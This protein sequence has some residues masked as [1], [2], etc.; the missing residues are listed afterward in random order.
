MYAN[1]IAAIA[2]QDERARYVD[3]LR[4]AY[5][6]DIDIVRLASELVVDSI[7]LPNEL[8]AA[9]IARLRAAR[10]KNRDFSRRRHGVTPV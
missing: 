3:E 10:T 1:K 7:V 9:L 8:R 2:D 6:E 4:E 5:E